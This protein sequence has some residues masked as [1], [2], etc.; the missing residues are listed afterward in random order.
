MSSSSTKSATSTVLVDAG[1]SS[2]SSARSNVTYLPFEVSKPSL[3]SSTLRPD[4]DDTFSC[5]T[6]LP[7][8]SSSWKWTLW[9]LVAE[10]AFT[11]T[12]TNPKLIDPDQIARAMPNDYP[13]LGVAHSHPGHQEASPPRFG[14]DR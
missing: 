13:L 14:H 7:L 3:I 9:S 4:F 6:R 8:E 11:G 12:L 5:C 1:R 2:S 10:N